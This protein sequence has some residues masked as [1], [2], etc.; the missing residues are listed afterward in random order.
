M[1]VFKKYILTSLF[2]AFLYFSHAQVS[3]QFVGTIKDSSTNIALPD[4]KVLGRENEGFRFS[5]NSS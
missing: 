3:G 2:S 1:Y 5:Q 4:L